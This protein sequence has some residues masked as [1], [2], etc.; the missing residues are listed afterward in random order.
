MIAED[1]GKYRISRKVIEDV[2]GRTIV[3]GDLNASGLLVLSI[4][5]KFPRGLTEREMLSELAKK[6]KRRS[7]RSS[8]PTTED[9][10]ALKDLSKFLRQSGKKDWSLK[11]ELNNLLSSGYIVSDIKS[12]V[13]TPMDLPD[14]G[15]YPIQYRRHFKEEE[16]VVKRKDIPKKSQEYEGED[17]EEEEN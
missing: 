7:H 4:L 9:E 16:K 13:I 15:T 14:L 6:A 10:E 12:E 1:E 17:I 11:E 3:P 8:K 5:I 2:A